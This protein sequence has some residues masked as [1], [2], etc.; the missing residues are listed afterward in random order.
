VR[1]LVTG[2]GGMLGSDACS[3]IRA[4]GHEAI[5]AGRAMFDVTDSSAVHAAIARLRP[6][7]VFHAAAHVDADEG[8]RSPDLPYRVNTI[9]TTNVAVACAREQVRL[10]YVS[11]CGVFDGTKTTPY[12]EL[13]APNPLTQH[14]RSKWF[15]ERVVTS[16]IAEH[17]I[18]R[19][20]WLFGGSA[21]HKKNFVARRFD[22][23]AGKESIVSAADRFGSPTYTMDFAAAALNIIEGGH[24]GTFHVVNEGQASRF[25]YVS[26]CIAALGLTTKVNSVSSESFPRSAPAPRSEALESFMMKEHELQP[27]RPWRD[28]LHE[29]TKTRLLPELQ[30]VI[31][32]RP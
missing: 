9:G 6:D 28:A 2:S 29:Y 22:E 18:L 19:P 20:G 23:A 1:F 10:A 16:L 13:D 30:P 24:F 26:E 32:S 14:H 8:E 5:A 17:V 31:A 7:V 11:S 12:T 27:L 4:R 15:G 25:E 3:V 21:A